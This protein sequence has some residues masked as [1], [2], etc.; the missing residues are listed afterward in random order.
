[1]WQHIKR[2]GSTIV[3]VFAMY[4][5]F[6]TFFFI[7]NLFFAPGFLLGLRFIYF[8]LLEGSTSGHIQS[9]ILMAVLLIVGFQVF[10]IGLLADLIANNRKLIEKILRD[11]K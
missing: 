8:Y 1:M 9:L 10:L 2:S 3:R 5:P 7:S 11:R 4:E 6:K